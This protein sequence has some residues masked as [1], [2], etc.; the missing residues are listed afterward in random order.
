MNT[1]EQNK[2]GSE[3]Y[4][5]DVMRIIQQAD[6]LG[7]VTRAGIPS[8]E[9]LPPLA[10]FLAMSCLIDGQRHGVGDK[11]LIAMIEKML[12][13]LKEYGGGNLP[14]SEDEFDA[15]NN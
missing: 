14:L 5:D 8:V 10:D 3:D 6:L 11:L 12:A 1:D 15:S 2:Q 7:A 13:N 9:L 4:Y